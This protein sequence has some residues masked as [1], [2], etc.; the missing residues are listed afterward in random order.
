LS[1]WSILV[2]RVPQSSNIIQTE[3]QIPRTWVL[4]PGGRQVS[5][6][7]RLRHSSL[8]PHTTWRGSSHLG[9]EIS[10]LL[11]IPG[12]APTCIPKPHH[13]ANVGVI[14]QMSD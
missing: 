6:R 1:T 4:T 13:H 8:M 14:Y 2:P 11:V 7:H 5:G 9:L 12:G 3:P 10:S